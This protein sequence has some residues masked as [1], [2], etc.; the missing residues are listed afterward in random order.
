M[1]TLDLKDII[2]QADFSPVY[3]GQSEQ[4]V[5]RALGKPAHRN[6]NRFGSIW[7]N[8]G[9]YEFSFFDNALHYF[10]NDHLKADCVNHADLIS[11]ENKHFSINPWFLKPNEDISMKNAIA[12]L[13]DQQV[14]FKI[15]NQKVA[16]QDY[17]V[18]EVKFLKLSNGISLNF[19]HFTTDFKYDSTGEVI[20]N[21]EVFF[22]NE[23]D[24][25]LY[26]IRYEHF[27][28]S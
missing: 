3:M 19:E 6:D 4:E 7:L 1:I 9:C 14:D 17:R 15:E 28:V 23:M 18:G 22:Q 10:Q 5:V 2:L 21:E 26:A 25:V 16:G 8:Y 24:F 27:N 13:E 20:D 12:L 11:Y